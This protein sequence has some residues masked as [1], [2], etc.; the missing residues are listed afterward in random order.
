MLL[1]QTLKD[2][3]ALPEEAQQQVAN[4]IEFMKYKHEAKKVRVLPKNRQKTKDSFQTIHVTHSVSPE[5]MDEAI[6]KG[7]IRQ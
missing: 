3:E 1:I 6:A 2:Y 7:A 5:E 4:F